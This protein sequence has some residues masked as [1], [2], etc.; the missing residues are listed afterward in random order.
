MDKTKELIILSE[1]QKRAIL[2]IKELLKEMNKDI[3]ELM[4][5]EKLKVGAEKVEAKAIRISKIAIALQKSLDLDN[6]G[7]VATNLDHLYKHIRFAVARVMDHNDYS[8]LTSA[9]KVTAEINKGWE[10]ISSAA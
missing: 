2:I 3:K 10:K 5:F 7:N 8:Y 9:E 6:G 1:K 4:D